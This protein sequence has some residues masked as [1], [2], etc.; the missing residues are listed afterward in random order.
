MQR[1]FSHYL[2]RERKF[3]NKHFVC[4]YTTSSKIILFLKCAFHNWQK[5]YGNIEIIVFQDCFFFNFSR[6]HNKLNDEK[7]IITINESKLI[8]DNF[9]LQV[10]TLWFF[11][12]I[13]KMPYL[14]ESWIYTDSQPL[15]VDVTSVFSYGYVVWWLLSL[16][17]AFLKPWHARCILCM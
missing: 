1:L 4:N 5:M 8:V 13:L 9:E 12:I 14:V 2:V 16:L 3:W 7:K 10:H 11:K 15:V 17:I 6:I